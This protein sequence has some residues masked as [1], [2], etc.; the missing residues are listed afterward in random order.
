M[1]SS[2]GDCYMPKTNQKKKDYT[3]ILEKLFNPPCPNCHS[4]EVEDLG[5][6]K[7]IYSFQDLMDQ[8]N[9]KHSQAH[10]YRCKK[11]MTVWDDSGGK[12]RIA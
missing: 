11:C 1:G 6:G 3:P 2:R 7:A 5:E 4:N 10:H 12:F 9:G 8:I